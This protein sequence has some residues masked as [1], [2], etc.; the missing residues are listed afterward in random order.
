MNDCP[1]ADIRDLLPDFIHGTLDGERRLKVERH[2]RACAD[3]TAEIALLTRVHAA[4]AEAPAVDVGRIVGALPVRPRRS[5]RHLTAWRVAATIAVVAL[6]SITFA[7]APEF[8]DRSAD[9]V[10]IASNATAGSGAH[11]LSF[12]GRLSDL[13]DDELDALLNEI[14]YYDAM[15]VEEPGVLVPGLPMGGSE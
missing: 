4:F 10:S 8:R 11:A 15:T 13:A 5:I 2:V 6:G 3:C 14:Q 7:L 1:N 12:G 9:S